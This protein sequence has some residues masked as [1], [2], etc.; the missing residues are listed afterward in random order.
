MQGICCLCDYVL[1]KLGSMNHLN[2]K[3]FR[4]L[5]IRPNQNP[6]QAYSNALREAE[7]LCKSKVQGFDKWLELFNLITPPELEDGGCFFSKPLH[8]NIDTVCRTLL[9]GVSNTDYEKHIQV[10]VEQAEQAYARHRG[11]DTSVDREISAAIQAQFKGKG[12]AG[13][14][15][16]DSKGADGGKSKNPASGTHQQNG[17]RGG[18]SQHAAGKWCPVHNTSNHDI[19]ECRETKA[20]AMKRHQDSGAQGV[21]TFTPGPGANP[22]DSGMRP[23]TSYGRAANQRPA[24]GNKS[25]DRASRRI[26]C[27]FCTK[28]NGGEQVYHAPGCFLNGEKPLPR[29]WQ[30]YQPRLLRTCNQLRQKQGWEALRPK[31]R[32]NNVTA[33]T[34]AGNMT[35]KAVNLNE[36][37][38]DTY[39]VMTTKLASVSV[40]GTA[41][42]QDQPEIRD[43]LLFD[44]TAKSFAC[45]GCNGVC[46]L[47]RERDSGAIVKVSCSTC[48]L[49]WRRTE[50]PM[51]W[52]AMVHWAYS[53]E[54]LPKARQ[55]P[56][57]PSQPAAPPSGPRPT[58]QQTP[59]SSSP[60]MDVLP[61]FQ[62][63]SSGRPRQ[64]LLPRSCSIST[65][66]R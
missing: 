60:Q 41:G 37:S 25:G 26:L 39:V 46:S 19:S 5:R 58:K 28:L 65:A 8:A 29:D 24:G 23:N 30:P 15:S 32:D 43:Q 3:A 36:G 62:P 31:P 16:A 38:G 18:G 6:R 2:V 4:A 42:H 11:T 33:A 51:A 59:A 27:D 45:Q 64:L 9:N 48:Q 53:D 40:A 20:F 61:L 54:H 34:P 1:L 56:A 35:A 10:Y 57:A 14:K 21:F 52:R 47:T 49:S 66:L 50:L 55:S 44:S 22:L 13:A 12:G 63:L 7:L 17:K